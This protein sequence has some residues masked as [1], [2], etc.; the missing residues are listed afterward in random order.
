MRKNILLSLL[1]GL[2]L[3]LGWPPF[4]YTTFLLF[5]GFVPMLIAV[6]NIVNSNFRKKGQKIFWTVFLGCFAW[7][8]LCTFWVYNALKIIGSVVALPVSLI[9]YSLG[10]L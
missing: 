6:E 1:S 8:T 4:H 5:I 10:P 3:W 7:N 9:P 2:L